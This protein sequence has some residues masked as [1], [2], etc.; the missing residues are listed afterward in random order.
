MSALKF[1]II[2]LCV[3]LVLLIFAAV[4]LLT[5]LARKIH[6][7]VF[8][9]RQDKNPR[10]KYFSPEDFNLQY[11]NIELNTKEAV[12]RGIVCGEGATTVVFCHG[13]GAGCAAYV[14]EIAKLVSFGYRVVAVDNLGCGISDGQKPRGIRAG[15]D[16]AELA[17]N[18]ARKRFGGKIVLVGHS[19][20]AYSALCATKA[21]KVEGVVA[22]AAPNSPAKMFADGAAPVIGA[23]AK[24]LPPFLWTVNQNRGGN[25]N[26]LKAAKCIEKSGVPALIIHGAEDNVVPLTNSVYVKA[27]GANVEKL[28]VLNRGHNPYNTVNAQKLLNDVSQNLALA[29]GGTDKQAE[30]FLQTVDYKAVCEEDE[31]VMQKIKDFIDKV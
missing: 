20:G 28:L 11:E 25:K 3:L 6:D 13:M 10:L 22:M 14:T 9:S 8:G 4:I 27:K 15:A 31:E 7:M 21:V 18:Y 30:K 17:V 1:L 24:I 16:C 26:N 2:V 19:W 29:A 23:L 12:L 5:V